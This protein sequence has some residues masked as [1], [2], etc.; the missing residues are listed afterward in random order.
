MIKIIFLGNI[1]TKATLTDMKIVLFCSD[2]IIEDL[3]DVN[4]S[5]SQ[6]FAKFHDAINY[7]VV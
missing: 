5:S 2:S 3:T 7:D 4:M 6:I 1:S